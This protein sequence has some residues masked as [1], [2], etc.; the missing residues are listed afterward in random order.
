M[1]LLFS[2][3]AIFA[4][5]VSVMHFLGVSSQLVRHE[6]PLAVSAL[7]AGLMISKK[8]EQTFLLGSG[9]RFS[10]SPKAT[11]KPNREVVVRK[12]C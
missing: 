1:A 4:L 10:S 7:R 6:N 5:L 12:F 11:A 3:F 9:S 2:V 8:L